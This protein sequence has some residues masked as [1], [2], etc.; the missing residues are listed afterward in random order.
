MLVLLMFFVFWSTIV[1]LPGVF[2][3]FFVQGDLRRGGISF[4]EEN[5]R[6]PCIFLR[7]NKEFQYKECYSPA[8]SALCMSGFA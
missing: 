6:K 8:V 7:E 2:F 3:V 5:G 4:D 1:I